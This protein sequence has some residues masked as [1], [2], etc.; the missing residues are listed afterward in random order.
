MYSR[1]SRSGVISRVMQHALDRMNDG[2]WEQY[3]PGRK[4]NQLSR[5]LYFKWGV[6]RLIMDANIPPVVLPLWHFGFEKI[7]PE[8]KL[9]QDGERVLHTHLV[10]DPGPLT[11]PSKWIGGDGNN[12][13][14][15][16]QIVVETSTVEVTTQQEEIK[17]NGAVIE[18]T[19]VTTTTTTT[20]T[21]NTI[22]TPP[23]TGF[24]GFI[25]RMTGVRLPKL[26]Q[27][28]TIAFGEPIDTRR[29]LADIQAASDVPLSNEE[30]RSK[31]SEY[32]WKKVLEVQIKVLKDM[33][34]KSKK[35]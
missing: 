18:S 29:V 24:V 3:F 31:L 23:S 34:E 5:M 2:K 32:C 6:G 27:P 21:S 33:D 1:N 26:F 8:P 30:L 22:P 16:E 13:G 25:E 17:P 10:E 19:N 35:I 7:L 12:N 14:E 28:V 11:K 15:L 9:P 4:V 20:V